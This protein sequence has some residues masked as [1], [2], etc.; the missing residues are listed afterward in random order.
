MLEEHQPNDDWSGG[1]NSTRSRDPG[2][3]N[4]LQGDRERQKRRKLEGGESSR[5]RLPYGNLFPSS[6]PALLAEGQSVPVISFSSRKVEAGKRTASTS[7]GLAERTPWR[8]VR[9]TRFNLKLRADILSGNRALN[10]ER[11][12]GGCSTRSGGRLQPS[13]FTRLA[14]VEVRTARNERH[15]RPAKGEP[16]RT[17]SATATNGDGGPSVCLRIYSG[18][19]GGGGVTGPLQRSTLS[20]RA[21]AV[22]SP[23]CSTS[24]PR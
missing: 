19:R 24:C 10:P 21:F 1:T 2:G 9:N 23:A 7:S 14:V 17:A 16:G 12:L 13:L 11:C 4:Q 5:R 8:R 15:V 20:Q 18:G 22:C 3:R 6:S